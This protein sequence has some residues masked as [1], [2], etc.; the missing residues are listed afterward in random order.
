VV[1][2][3][4]LGAEEFGFGKLLLVAQGCI[5]ARICET[6]RCPTGIATHDPKFKAKYKGTVDEIESFVRGLADGVREELAFLGLRRLDELVGQRRFLRAKARFRDLVERRGID[7]AELLEPVEVAPRTKRAQAESSP[8]NRKIIDDVLPRLDAGERVELDY[9]ITS[10][11][12]AVGAGLAGE[13]GRRAHRARMADLDG[14]TPNWRS[15]DPPAGSIALRF[16]GSAGQGFAAF[17]CGGVHIELRGEAND[18]VAKSMA[19]GR[20]V[21]R[22]PEDAGFV[23]EASVIVGNCCLYGATGGTLFVHGTA[24]DRFAVRNSGAIAVVDGAGLHACEYMT[25]GTVVILGR[26]SANAGAGM[27][28]GELWIPAR[29]LLALNPTLVQPTD[30]SEQQFVALEAI[31]RDYAE[32]TGSTFAR[33]LLQDPRRLR[34]ALVRVAPRDR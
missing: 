33:A 19:S 18:A 5:M 16:R 8:L 29:E 20:V 32:A 17:T 15:Y 1:L 4:A 7:L 25:G 23:P 2:A 3:A 30:A 22:P 9:A 27:T 21:V 13:L 31:L 14:K 10:C 34:S 11:D 6:N 26:L 12:R 24:G 28:G